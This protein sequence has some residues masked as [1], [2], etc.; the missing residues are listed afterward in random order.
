MQRSKLC[1]PGLC[2]PG[3]FRVGQGDPG[4]SRQGGQERHISVGPGQLVVGHRGQHSDDP[5]VMKQRGDE[6]TP[7]SSGAAGHKQF[8]YPTFRDPDRGQ[9]TGD[10]AGQAGPRDG[11]QLVIFEDTDR[12]EVHAQR[13]PRLLRDRSEQ[14]LTVTR[15]GKSFRDAEDSGP[16]T[17]EFRCQDGIGQGVLAD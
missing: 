15:V 14:V 12:D 5:V 7:D 4:M 16:A 6:V 11:D 17:R 9:R 3:Q 13:P 10:L 2:L 8:A 1:G